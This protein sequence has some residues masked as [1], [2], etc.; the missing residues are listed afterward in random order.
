MIIGADA[1]RTTCPATERDAPRVVTVQ[2]TTHT[3]YNN[4]RAPLASTGLKHR[5]REAPPEPPRGYRLAERLHSSRPW[6]GRDARPVAPKGHQ[7]R[8]GA[9]HSSAVHEHL[10]DGYGQRCVV[11]MNHLQPL[12]LGR[13]PRMQ[14]GHH[15]H[16]PSQQSRRR[17]GSRSQPGTKAI[18]V[19]RSPV[20][21]NSRRTDLVDVNSRRIVV[22]GDHRYGF[23][24]FVLPER[25]PRLLLRRRR[26]KNAP[27]T[28]GST[29]ASA[30]A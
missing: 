12:A 22:S 7:Q 23:A 1:P 20:E 10:V 9:T 25:S 21:G 17:V 18:A 27:G 6:P 4:L 15:R 30:E 5:S 3:Q 13:S 2:R 11:T 16:A 28:D 19:V 8:C 29:F 26:A 24:L 14:P